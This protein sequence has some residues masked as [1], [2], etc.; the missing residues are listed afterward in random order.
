MEQMNGIPQRDDYQLGE[1]RLTPSF[2]KTFQPGVEGTSSQKQLDEG[3]ATSWAKPEP[4]RPLQYGEKP[5][6][7]RPQMG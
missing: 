1:A 7:R 5:S 4:Q 2:K 6:G 3:K